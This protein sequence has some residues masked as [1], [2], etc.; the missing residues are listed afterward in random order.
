MAGFAVANEVEEVRLPLL[1]LLGPTASGKSALAL[2][3]AERLDRLGRRLELVSVDSAQV[4]RGMDIGTAKPSAAE[5]A[6][7]PHHLLDCCDPADPYSASRFAA[8]ARRC[9]E[10]IHARGALPLLVGGTMLYWRALRLGLAELP[11]ADATIRGGLAA[12]AEQL[13]WPALHAQLAEV[14]PELAS[15]LAA[16]D[17]QR[18]GR[19]L[20]VYRQTGVPLSRLQRQGATAPWPYRE[21]VFALWPVDRDA[22]RQRI[23]QR[24]ATMLASGL[25][26]EVEALRARGD[27]HPGLPSIKSAGYRQT[28]TWL[29]GGYGQ[30]AEA[31]R[32]LQE[33]GG[34]ATTQ[35]AKRQLTWIRGQAEIERV[36][37]QADEGFAALF[38]RWWQGLE[39]WW[40]EETEAGR[41]DASGG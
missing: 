5:R 1:A 4:Y 31:R 18:I 3:L 12:E 29:D 10:A 38:T 25:I 26:E 23:H 27:L 28:W 9:I 16:N 17:A 7:V 34:F 13:G 11:P 6:L 15:R 24:F 36:P 32:T 35:L 8:D 22:L 39:S 14:D 33:R 30:G 37:V 19:G 21:R 20:E 40:D 2:A 41:D